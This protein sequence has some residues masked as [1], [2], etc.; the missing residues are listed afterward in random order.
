[1][2]TQK[3]YQNTVAVANT[4]FFFTDTCCFLCAFPSTVYFLRETETFAPALER[5][6]PLRGH[7]EAAAG[8]ERRARPRR[9]GAAYN[10]IVCK[11]QTTNLFSKRLHYTIYIIGGNFLFI[12]RLCISAVSKVCICIPT[13]TAS[14]QKTFVVFVKACRRRTFCSLMPILSIHPPK[15]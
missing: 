11:I 10:R 4:L 13:F 9:P 1:M 7:V 15:R 2:I 3:L 5:A 12:H 14:L 6:R 8:A